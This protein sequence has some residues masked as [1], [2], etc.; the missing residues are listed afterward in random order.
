[1][2]I[3][4]MDNDQAADALVKIAGA[5]SFVSDDADITSLIDQIK[6]EDDDENIFAII[7]RYLPRIITL[8]LKKHRASVYEIVSALTGADN[9]EV[10][11][12]NFK[13]TVGVIMEN[14][15]ELKAFFPWPASRTRREET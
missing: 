5:Y 6:A 15:E 11:K 8:A 4:E 12:M 9:K 7:S 2:R 1:M 14:W 13:E 3:S 10:G